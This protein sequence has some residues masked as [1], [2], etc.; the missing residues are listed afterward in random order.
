M[1]DSEIPPRDQDSRQRLA[2]DRESYPPRSNF[3]IP[4][5]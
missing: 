4:D 1:W 3:P 5:S 2:I